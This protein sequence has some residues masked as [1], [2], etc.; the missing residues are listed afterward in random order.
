ML[1]H[2]QSLGVRLRPHMK[3][4]K[5]VQIARLAVGLAVDSA[6][7]PSPDQGITVSTLSEAEYFAGHGFSDI[8]YAVP[9]PASK[10]ENA[11][12]AQDAGASKLTLSV[13][14]LV[15][16]TSLSSKAA[17]LGRSFLVAIEVDCGDD[18]CGLDPFK[19]VDELLAT[20]RAI[21]S[22]K[23]LKLRGLYTH[24]GH[25]YRADGSVELQRIAE[26]ERQYVVHA[27]TLLR[28]A[29]L[30]VEM[31]SVGSTPT[32]THTSSLSGITEMRP[33]VYTLGDTF[34]TLLGACK[35][36]NIAMTVLTTVIAHHKKSKR[37]IIDAGALALSKDISTARWGP[38]HG[39]GLVL[40]PIASFPRNDG[41]FVGSVTQ[42][43]GQLQ[44]PLKDGAEQDPPYDEFPIGSTLRIIPNHACLTAA[45]HPQYHLITNYGTTVSGT[46]TRLNFW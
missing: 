46:W 22:S 36:E 19:E 30:P 15:A 23:H 38:H 25:S 17:S 11:A 1:D 8:L 40:S 13:D 7:A 10:L 18:R 12:A 41:L 29:G 44:L 42:E 21:H 16:A 33:G 43:H 26:Q 2:A 20:A 35:F 39:Y 4:T 45:A 5:C 31:V 27:A 28:E 32:A 3:T 34:Q 6:V 37:I 24:A 14:S 9:C